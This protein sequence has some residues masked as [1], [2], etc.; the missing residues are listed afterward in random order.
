M[1]PAMTEDAQEWRE[2]E[3]MGQYLILEGCTESLSS[4]EAREYWTL[5]MKTLDEAV[6]NDMRSPEVR[7]SQRIVLLCML[8]KELILHAFDDVAKALA[9]QED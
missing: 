8:E 3:R 1:L 6:C 2:R 5:W 9:K 7:D 4:K